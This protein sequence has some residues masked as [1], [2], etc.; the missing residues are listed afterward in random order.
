[1]KTVARTLTNAGTPAASVRSK[2]TSYGPG[3]KR[4]RGHEVGGVFHETRRGWLILAVVW[5]AG[6][7]YLALYLRVGWV[8]H[9]AGLFGEAADRVLR[10][11]VPYRDFTEVYTG[12]LTFLNALAF[13]LFGVNLFSLRLPLFLFFLGWVPSVYFIARRFATPIAA[14]AVTLLAVA[15][16][17]PNYSEAM[18]SWYNLFFAIWGVLALIRYMET[19]RRRWLWIAGACAGLSFLVKIVAL[20]FIAAALLFFVFREGSLSRHSENGSARG[21]IPYRIFVSGGLLLFLAGLIGTVSQRPTATDFFCFVLPSACLVSL[22]IREVWRGP[23]QPSGLRFRRLFS[24]AL[25][26]L[27]GAFVPIAVFLAYYI[28]A[29]AIEAWLSGILASSIRIHWAAANPPPLLFILGLV[30]M[31]LVLALAYSRKTAGRRWDWLLVAVALA[32]LLALARVSPHVYLVFGLSPADLVPL[33]ALVAV[34]RLYRSES[35]SAEKRQLLFLLAA[36][37]V[38]CALVQFPFAV[39]LYFCFVAP[40]VIL[41][42]VC[43]L[44]TIGRPDRAVLSALLVF[45]LAFAVWLRAP[46][47]YPAQYSLLDRRISLAELNLPRGGG[48]YVP[49]KQAREY[50]EVVRLVR[51]H[52]RGGYIYAT[53]DSPEVCFLS[54]LR[55]PTGAMYDFLD[56]DYLNPPARNNRILHTLALFRVHVVVLAPPDPGVSGVVSPALRA[57]LDAHFPKSRQV[58]GF[59]VRWR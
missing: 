8:P 46:G 6:A 3:E 27:G 51:A 58:G 55:N 26:F 54:G 21:A 16:S 45:Y 53:P 29:G 50:D 25:P 52:D 17:V 40:L 14:G 57:A 49:A 2:H 59:D 43:L 18:P 38:V 39:P 30:P 1:M 36:A 22:L 32:A 37:A 28:K 19:E 34:A 33:L 56:P 20:Y 10:G 48:I 42:L 24:M 23:T 5:L 31:A 13:R 4:L 7:V 47:A 11:Q 35:L 15:W 41:M 9:D 12:G 44:S